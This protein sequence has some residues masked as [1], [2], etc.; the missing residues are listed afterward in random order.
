LLEEGRL[1]CD[2]LTNRGLAE[3]A[4]ALPPKDYGLE[5]LY[6][7]ACG[8]YDDDYTIF[9]DRTMISALDLAPPSKQRR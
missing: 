6:R 7:E 5:S 4:E 2:L 3:F 8:N 1:V 9:S